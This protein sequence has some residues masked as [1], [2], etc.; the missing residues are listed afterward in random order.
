MLK[1][2]LPTEMLSS[3]LEA[4]LS[5]TAHWNLGWPTCASVVLTQI[6]VWVCPQQPHEPSAVSNPTGLMAH[7]EQHL[8]DVSMV[9]PLCTATNASSHTAPPLQTPF[10][11][12]LFRTHTFGYF[13]SQWEKRN[14]DFQKPCNSYRREQ[15]FIEEHLIPT[16]VS[17]AA[18]Q[19][20]L[21]TVAE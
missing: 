1:R 20:L 5:S 21:P 3:V 13:Y 8:G 18:F 4:Q 7:L 2:W 6:P 12:Q 14:S 16:T 9:C 11:A 19:C 15:N 10:W 17:E